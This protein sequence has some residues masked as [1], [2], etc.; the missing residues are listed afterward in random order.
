M[1][2]GLAKMKVSNRDSHELVVA[3]TEMLQ[4]ACGWRDVPPRPAVIS[5]LTPAAVEELRATD[6]V[7]AAH[8]LSAWNESA[9]ARSF[10]IAD[11]IGRMRSVLYLLRYW[12][13][14]QRSDPDNAQAC[15]AV[16]KV[17]AF[18][19]DHWGIVTPPMDAGLWDKYCEAHVLER[20]HRK[21][22]L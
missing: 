20:A 15:E 13:K 18:A 6:D 14:R 5:H 1:S 3:T 2:R 17:W 8:V 12:R 10:A 7:T 16:L 11:N 19:R 4:E 22:R 21:E 9:I